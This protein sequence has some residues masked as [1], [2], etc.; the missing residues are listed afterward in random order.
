MKSESKIQQEIYRY[1]WNNFCLPNKEPREIIYHIPNEGK[2]NGRLISVGLYPG[3]SDLVFTYKGQ[4]YYC[5]VKDL[6]GKQST[7][8]IKFQKHVIQS[9]YKYFV[10]RSLGEFQME[11]RKISMNVKF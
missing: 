10:V 5:E 7:N 8:Q 4:H 3:A 2:G 6:T 1:Y 9:G 11:L